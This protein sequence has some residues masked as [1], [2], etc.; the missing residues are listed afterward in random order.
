M[1]SYNV[2]QPRGENQELRATRC[3]PAAPPARR[4]AVLDEHRALDGHVGVF[5]DVY[6]TTTHRSAVGGEV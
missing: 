4:S 6:R 3:S 1:R 2:R 5:A